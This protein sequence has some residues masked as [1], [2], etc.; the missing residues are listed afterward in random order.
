MIKFCHKCDTKLTYVYDYDE[1]QEEEADFYCQGCL[2]PE[3]VIQVIDLIDIDKTVETLN[4][5]LLSTRMERLEINHK[6]KKLKMIIDILK[7]H[8]MKEKLLSAM[9]D[10]QKLME[11]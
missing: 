8:Q 4:S 9:E 7:N 2:E 3:D 6:I 11:E 5:Q 1:E 10:F